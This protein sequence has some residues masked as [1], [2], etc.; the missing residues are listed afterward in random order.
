MDTSRTSTR[1]LMRRSR[2]SPRRRAACRGHPRRARGSGRIR[3]ARRGRPR[4][5]VPARSTSRRH[6][7]RWRRR[8]RR[9]AF[10]DDHE[11]VVATVSP[12]SV[13]AFSRA[14][15]TASLPGWKLASTE[16]RMRKPSPAPRRSMGTCSWLSAWP[17]S[18]MFW[19]SSFTGRVCRLREPRARSMPSM[20]SS[21][22]ASI[23]SEALPS[24]T[25]LVDMMFL[26]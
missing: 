3:R 25:P 22:G 23:V 6:R 21:C 24:M 17:I 11:R 16:K 26:G 1:R 5:R 7:G 2:R 15:R 9:C 12:S 13:S 14:G 19:R 10:D 8:R 18:S 4:R 20:R